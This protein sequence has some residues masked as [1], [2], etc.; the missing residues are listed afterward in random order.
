MT[1]VRATV[2]HLGNLP[3]AVRED[4]D[5]ED[6]CYVLLKTDEP[7][8]R[9]FGEYVF[10]PADVSVQPVDDE[11]PD[12]P[13]GPLFEHA[14]LDS[15]P[16]NDAKV[17]LVVPFPNGHPSCALCGKDEVTHVAVFAMKKDGQSGTA[18]GAVCDA[19]AEP[20]VAEIEPVPGAN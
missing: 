12:S 10:Q 11:A 3:S 14:R 4:L 5:L 7:G 18:F 15:V 6:G 17:E 8:V 19:C 16:K 2:V 1:K 13:E 20:Y 9:A